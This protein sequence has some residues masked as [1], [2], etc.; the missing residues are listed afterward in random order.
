MLRS[1]FTFK[2]RDT[3]FPYVLFICPACQVVN[4]E[5]EGG[6]TAAFSMVAFTEKLCERKTTIYG[7]KVGLEGITENKEM[8]Q[9]CINTY[10]Q[11]YKEKAPTGK[12]YINFWLTDHRVTLSNPPP[13]THTHK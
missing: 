9:F 10:K 7:S 3:F 11:F 5:F 2:K 4:M 6:L 1:L 12:R 13:P 8:L